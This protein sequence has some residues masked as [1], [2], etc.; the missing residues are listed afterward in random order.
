MADQCLRIPPAFLAEERSALG[1][2]WYNQ[3]YCCSFQD[4]VDQVFAHV[5]IMAALSSDLEPL[6]VE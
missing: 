1:S 5:D 6:F 4:T 2:R 3:E